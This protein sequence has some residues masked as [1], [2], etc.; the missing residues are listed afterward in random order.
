MFQL[1]RALNVVVWLILPLLVMYNA[2][3]VYSQTDESRSVIRLLSDAPSLRFKNLGIKDGLAQSSANNIMQGQE[4]KPLEKTP[5]QD[6]KTIFEQNKE[7]M[8]QRVTATTDDL[9]ALEIGMKME[10]KAINFYQ[11][12]ASQ[13]S[14]PAEKAFFECL[15]KDEEEHFTIFQNTHSFISDTGNWFMWDEHSIVEG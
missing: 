3:P 1:V 13:A 12:A 2:T 15:I 8:L 7:A 14:N 9:E 11:E 4:V 5:L 10:E 6:M